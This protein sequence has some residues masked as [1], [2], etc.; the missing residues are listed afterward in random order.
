ML[1]KPERYFIF[2]WK[3]I[4]VILLLGVMGTGFFF[5]LGLH[6][7][8]KM[9]ADAVNETAHET[10]AG[11]S[12]KLQEGPETLP[13]RDT[14]EQASRH[15]LVATEDSIK[16]TTQEE[17][18][19]AGVKLEAPKQVDLPS[20]KTI[21]KEPA[22]VSHS[23][24]FAIQLGSFPSRAEANKKIKDYSQHGVT[25]SVMIAKVGGKTRFRVVVTGFNSK[26]EA[27]A[28]ANQLKAKKK[29]DGFVIIRS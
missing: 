23:G 1:Q 13:S 28:Q 25:A 21:S 8:K 22:P 27:E 10:P 19:K 16:K 29:I 3:E 6:Y 20:A 2:S 17:L 5:T 9:H 7:G 15:A 14:L 11:E 4:L 26:K 18:K 24:A 12:E